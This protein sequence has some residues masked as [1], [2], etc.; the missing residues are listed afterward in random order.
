MFWVQQKK[1]S[2][3]SSAKGLERFYCL[4]AKRASSWALV[5]VVGLM[6]ALLGGLAGELARALFDMES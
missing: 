6:L 1:S 3:S 2:C 5:L 4:Y